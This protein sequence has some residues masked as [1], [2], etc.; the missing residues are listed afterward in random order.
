MSSDKGPTKKEAQANQHER[1]DLRNKI[2]NLEWSLAQKNRENKQLKS[3]IEHCKQEVAD[4]TAENDKL[5]GNSDS[6]G[7]NAG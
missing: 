3:D 5:K 1:Q 4:L 7:S 2:Q 6:E